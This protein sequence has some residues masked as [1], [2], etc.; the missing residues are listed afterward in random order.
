[1][2][3]RP[4]LCRRS[5]NIWRSRILALEAFARYSKGGHPAGLNFGDCF[6]YACAK[7]AAAPLLYRAKA[8]PRPISRPRD[9]GE[10][11]A[12]Y[13]PS[14]QAIWRAIAA[15]GNVLKRFVALCAVLACFAPASAKDRWGEKLPG[16]P[17][18]FIF[19]YGSLIN[20]A[21][22]NSTAGAPVPALPVRISAAFGYFRTWNDRSPSGFTALGVRRA[23]PGETGSTI[24]GVLYP[25]E[26]NDMA[27]YD[28]REKGYARV[29]VPRE[30]IEALS[31]RRLPESGAIWVYAPV[32]PDGQPGVGLPPP[33]A[34]YPLLESYVDVVVEGGL[35]YGEDFARELLETT[36]GWSD[37]WLNDRELA[38]RPWVHDPQSAEV[39]A[40]LAAAPEAAAKLK[41][42]LFSETYTLRWS[43]QKAP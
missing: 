5:S 17:T 31:W 1:V 40:L 25:V 39:D 10:A 11:F 8:S 21:S 14:A 35:E 28:L 27:K 15:G 29:E 9:D 18:N 12:C 3:I 4:K 43:L 19:G 16:Q 36:D 32:G 7:L 33:D 22:R 6:A 42:R 34:Q 37:Y 2:S 13:A 24:N 38:R 41:S 23:G 20:S 26:G 30:D